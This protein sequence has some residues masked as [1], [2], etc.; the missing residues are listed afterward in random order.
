M[1]INENGHEIGVKS[2]RLKHDRLRTYEC[3]FVKDNS[4]FEE[5]CCFIR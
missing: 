4:I 5:F 2:K 3:L 1:F